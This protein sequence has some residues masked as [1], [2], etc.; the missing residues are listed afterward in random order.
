MPSHV[1]GKP[2]AE[3]YCMRSADFKNV[4]GDCR[5]QSPDFTLKLQGCAKVF[6]VKLGLCNL[7]FPY[8]FLESFFITDHCHVFRF[9]VTCWSL[10]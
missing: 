2:N 9:L 8:T 5:L 6:R 10:P 4:Y 1:T 3:Q 7:G